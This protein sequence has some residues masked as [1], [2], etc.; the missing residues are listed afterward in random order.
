MK[1]LICLIAM[2]ILMSGCAS[3]QEFNVNGQRAVENTS[4]IFNR[5][6]NVPFKEVFLSCLDLL[7]DY[8][9]E[10]YLKD[11]DKGIILAR[12]AAG[13][14]SN[15]SMPSDNVG[16]YFEKV[17]NQETKVTLKTAASIFRRATPKYFLD[18][19]EKEIKFRERIN[20]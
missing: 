20:R 7:H 12:A 6:Y 13:A 8:N 16:I 18:A 3:M 14:A 19:I 5:I 4:H 10:I 15:W 9:A 17:N 11:F 2:L 1:R